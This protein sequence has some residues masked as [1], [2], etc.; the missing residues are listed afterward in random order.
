MT[1]MLIDRGRKLLNTSF[2]KL[3]LCVCL[4]AGAF[5]LKAQ[6]EPMYS[7]YMFNMMH[8]NPAYAG[9]RA[10][11]NITLLYRK[12][13][14][15][16][17][18]APQTGS[19]SW[20]RRADE[21]NVGYGLQLYY[22]QLGIEKTTGFQAFYSYRIAFE[23]AFLSL[24]LSAGLL[25]YRADYSQV[26]TI[27][28][29]DPRF[30]KDV[31]GWLPTIGFGLLYGTDT[32]YAGFS[33]PALLHTKIDATNYLNQKNMGANNHYFLTGG[34]VF[35]VSDYVKIKPSLL[36]KAVKGAPLECDFNVNGWF[37]DVIGLGVSYRTGDALVGMAEIQLSPRLRLGYAYDYTI[38][39]LN[40]F[41]KG[42][43]EIM[44]R[45]EFDKLKE[46]R[47][48]SPRYY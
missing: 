33:I 45:Y 12:Q 22:D 47:I 39:N 15:G 32:W 17:D 14:V 31:N 26:T 40:V 36:L 3:F 23:N 41:S 46:Q 30:Q 4:L 27:D 1:E 37:Y 28:P 18:N 25:N 44:L 11:D 10:V 48:L 20:D 21:S 16:I 9:N 6:Q 38:S 43:H 29:G 35:S 5:Q 13:W 34:Y 2:V 19:V 24:G 8:I 42:T 7:Q